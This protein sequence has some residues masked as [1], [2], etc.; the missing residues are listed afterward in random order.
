MHLGIGDSACLEVEESQSQV[1]F[2]DLCCDYSFIFTQFYIEL[3]IHIFTSKWTLNCSNDA[4]PSP[5]SMISNNDQ[6]TTN[7]KRQKRNKRKK[8]AKMKRTKGN[9]IRMP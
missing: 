5:Y 9:R 2:A 6:D 8:K 1:S 4:M 3:F 7:N